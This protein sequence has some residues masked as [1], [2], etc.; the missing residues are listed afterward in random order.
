MVQAVAEYIPT[1]GTCQCTKYKREGY[2][3]LLQPLPIP[4]WKWQ[5]VNM[6]LIVELPT[7]RCAQ[8][9]AIVFVNRLTKMVCVA[10]TTTGISVE[11]CPDLFMSEVFRTSWYTIGVSEWSWHLLYFWVL[12]TINYLVECMTKDEHNI[13]SSNT[14]ANRS[15]EQNL[16]GLSSGVYMWLPKHLGWLADNG[17]IR[18]GQ[19]KECIY[20]RDTILPELWWASQFAPYLEHSRLPANRQG[21]G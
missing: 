9:V 5:S 2:A 16:W 18:S 20:R 4:E 8:D 3:G 21:H 11:G 7:T 13:P 12:P 15:D 17:R 6:D 19:C 1:Y 10:P 14:W